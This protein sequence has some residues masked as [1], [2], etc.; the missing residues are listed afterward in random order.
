MSVIEVPDAGRASTIGVAPRVQEL[1]GTENNP[2]AAIVRT[3]SGCGAGDPAAEGSTTTMFFP[4]TAGAVG[5][6]G[7]TSGAGTSCTTTKL[8]M[9]ESVAPGFFIWTLSEPAEARSDAVSVVVQSPFVSHKVVRGVPATCMTDPGPGLLTT[10]FPPCTRRVKPPALPESAL[11]GRSPVIAAPVVI[12]TLALPACEVSS[13]LVAT[14]TIESGDGAEVGAVKTPTEVI[15]PQGEP[16]PE[17][18]VPVTFHVT[19]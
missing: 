4:V 18:A 15:A 12:E 17:Q 19:L 5:V 14:M 10:K 8:T 9:F 11:A 3:T 1:F 6:R 7:T 13:E 16:T 2:I